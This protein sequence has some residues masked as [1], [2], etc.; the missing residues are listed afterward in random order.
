MDFLRLLH[1]W[2][3]WLLVIV[4]I[5][6]LVYFAWGLLQKRSW[7][8]NA[9]LLMRV[10]PIL[11]DIQWLL[12]LLFFLQT[13]AQQG[14]MSRHGWEHAFWMT[15]TLVV[16]HVPMAWRKRDLPDSIRYRNNLLVVIG[17]VV[18][19]LVGIMTL[20]SPIQWRFYTGV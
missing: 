5:A 20:P 18:L 12:G 8:K 6:A 7:D 10:L 3:R 11:V 1:S 17:V 13:W 19:V 2:N 4:V 16:A 14:G 9:D 15:L